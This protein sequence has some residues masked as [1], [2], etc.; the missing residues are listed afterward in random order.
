M[1]KVVLF[2]GIVIFALALGLGIYSNQHSPKPSGLL[3]LN[4]EALAEGHGGEGEG[5][6]DCEKRDC[7]VHLGLPP[8]VIVKHGYWY[9][10]VQGGSTNR[11]ADCDKNCDAL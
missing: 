7:E 4:I 8:L 11:C 10:C 6:Y 5:P 1:K 3:A 2:F 9:K